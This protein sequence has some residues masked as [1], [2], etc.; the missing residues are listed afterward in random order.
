MF[1]PTMIAKLWRWLGLGRIDQSSGPLVVMYH[2]LGGEDGL[3]PSEFDAQ[4]SHL[5]AHYEIVPLRDAV[6]VLGRPEARQLASITFD[7]GYCDFAEFAIPI[8][9]SHG[10]HATLFV[11]AGKLGTHNE[12]D[13]G[14]RARRPI[15]DEV[16]LRALDRDHVEIGAHGWTHCRMA[17]LNHRELQK[18]TV[19]ARRKLE[20]LVG[21]KVDLFA[22]PYGQLDDF[23]ASAEIAVREA[24]FTA[25]CSTHYGRGSGLRERYRLRRIGVEP[26]DSLEVFEAKIRGD[27]DWQTPKERLGAWLRRRTR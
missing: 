19:H 9:K 1:E 10:L 2:G 23:D 11:P 8:L 15:L 3:I 20:E 4:C 18:E 12:W 21:V 6:A 17:G 14:E 27:Y 13:E 26:G 22:Y 25:A 24:G 5:S 7:D 16:S